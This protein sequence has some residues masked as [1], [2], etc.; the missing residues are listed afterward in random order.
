MKVRAQH[1]WNRALFEQTRRAVNFPIQIW[2][3]SQGSRAGVGD[4]VLPS[5]GPEPRPVVVVVLLRFF[6]FVVRAPVADAAAE[7]RAA[8][9]GQHDER[10]RADGQ[11][12]RARL[13]V[14][15]YF[16]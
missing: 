6:D 3:K 2:Q 5:R 14:H 1:R 13:G 8:E 12:T 15:L 4:R 11:P 10:G 7:P 9:E 16:F